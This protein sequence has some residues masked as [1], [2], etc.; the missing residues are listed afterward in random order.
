MAEH[1]GKSV[2]YLTSE[3]E[4]NF[5]FL[6]QLSLKG[7][8]SDFKSS[9]DYPLGWRQA[10]E[11]GEELLKEAQKKTLNSGPSFSLL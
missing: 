8:T 6:S 2:E 11:R 7:V 4:A 9:N 5:T 1:G 3:T 10:I